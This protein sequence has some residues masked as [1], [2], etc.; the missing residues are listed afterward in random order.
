MANTIRGSKTFLLGICTGALLLWGFFDHS[1]KPFSFD[2]VPW[3]QPTWLL[4]G[5]FPIPTTA[6]IIEHR[7]YSVAYD[8]KTK[9]P[10][11]VYHKLTAESLTDKGDRTTCTFQEDPLLPERIRA[12][13]KD[14][15]A[16][17]FDRGH[18]APAQNQT[19][20]TLQESFYLSNIA[21]QLP[22]FN[23][24]VWKR[25]ENK[26]RGFLDDYAVL[27]VFTGPLYLPHKA[28]GKRVV[29]YQ[30]IGD[31][32]VAV[33]THFFALI[34]AERNPGHFETKSYILP[35]KGVSSDVPLE[36]FEVDLGRIESCTGVVFSKPSGPRS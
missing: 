28:G 11:W 15:E 36:R 23:R 21:P 26:I 29:K 16:S 12:I 34:F 19:D 22:E 9:T 4:Q 3:K 18:L 14:Y 10:I 30:V 20:E 8:G 25:L 7:G 33:P 27:H 2:S 6:P 17:G 13:P 1:F 32:D 5:S 24:G 31:N 35:N